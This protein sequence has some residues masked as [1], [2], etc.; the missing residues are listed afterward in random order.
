MRNKFI[1]RLIK[2]QNAKTDVDETQPQKRQVIAAAGKLRIQVEGK[3]NVKK[4]N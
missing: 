3:T 2:N 1:S 4:R